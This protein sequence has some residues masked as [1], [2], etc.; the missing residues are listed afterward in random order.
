MCNVRNVTQ[1]KI[2]SAT[3]QIQLAIVIKILELLANC[4]KQARE[5]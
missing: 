4:D 5:Q 2:R 3:L 1:K